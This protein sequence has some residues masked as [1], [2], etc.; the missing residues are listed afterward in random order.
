MAILAL[1]LWSPPAGAQGL[2][3]AM[4]AEVDRLAHAQMRESGF[5]GLVVGIQTREHGSYLQAYG[6]AARADGRA[7]ATG[8]RFRVGSVTKTFT[9]TVILRLVQR[10]QLR[11]GD[12]LRRWFP[13]FPNAG[14]ITVRMMLNHTSGIPDAPPSWFE[15]WVDSRG[16]LV[17]TPAEMIRAASRQPPEFAPGTGYFYS[18]TDYTLLGQIAER[19]T[20]RPIR[21]LYRRW[22]TRPLRM[23]DTAYRPNAPLPMPNARGYLIGGRREVDVT[24]WSFS[25]V[26]TAGGISSTVPD[27]LRYA[28]ALATGRGLLSRA[29]QRRRLRDAVATGQSGMRYGL[30]IFR[31]P[32]EV[33]P[34]RFEP[35]V[36]HDGEVAGYNAIVLHSR[37]HDASLVVLGNTSPT[38]NQAPQYRDATLVVQLAAEIFAA[39]YAPAPADRPAPPG[40]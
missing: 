37:A 20:G 15:R 13:D 31:L 19:V 23:T 38:L 6:V 28:P 9:G 24:D 1:A 17:I 11:L 32:V 36:G 18:N 10:G 3:D 7:M 35:L 27:L 2:D 34:G 25:W 39:L 40:R 8:D 16:R 30:G 14:R 5:P 22:I 29:V 4:R 33:A 21:A 26:N 12:R